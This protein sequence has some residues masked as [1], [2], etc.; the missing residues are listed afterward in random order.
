MF[1]MGFF[2]HDDVVALKN[3]RDIFGL[4]NILENTKDR[5][6]RIAAAEAL[7]TIEDDRSVSSLLSVLKHDSEE[8]RMFAALALGKI[9]NVRAVLPLIDSLGD[10]HH[11]V[12]E[13]T[14]LALGAIG[15]S[16]AISPLQ[17]ALD[18][19]YEEVRKAAADS[20]DTLDEADTGCLRY[21]KIGTC[22]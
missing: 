3:K 5:P 10:N 2:G 16:R 17:K 21:R 11:M 14:A 13:S 1:I 22:G 12:R 9:G 20:L 7:G 15:D 18:D 8:V 19:P 4:Q 6:L